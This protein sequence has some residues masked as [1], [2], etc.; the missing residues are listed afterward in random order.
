MKTVQKTNSHAESELEVQTTSNKDVVDSSVSSWSKVDLSVFSDDIVITTITT[1]LS[2]PDSL[3]RQYVTGVT[4]Q[5]AERSSKG[6]NNIVSASQENS[7]TVFK[8]QNDA[9]VSAASEQKEQSDTK[10]E[11][12][13]S[14]PSWVITLIA[15]IF[16][17]VLVVILVILRHYRII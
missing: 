13:I 16:A 5:V 10:Q 6:C 14:T 15:S 8:E 17:V 2:I 7:E 1:T 11:V 9:S 4:K 3:G 12:K